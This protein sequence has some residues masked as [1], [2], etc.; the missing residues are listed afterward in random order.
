MN[1]GIRTLFLLTL[2]LFS[3]NGLAQQKDNLI[4]GNFQNVS[5]N[6]F[7][8]KVEA[9]TDYHFY[10]EAKQFDSTTITISVTNAHLPSIL[11]KIFNGTQWRYVIDKD[12]NVFITQ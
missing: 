4:T 5:F 2:S 8:R 3:L 9:Q 10:Y 12:N 1:R 7:A 11:D 6:E